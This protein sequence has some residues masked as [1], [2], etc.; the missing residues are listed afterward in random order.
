MALFKSEKLESLEDLLLDQLRDIYDAEHRIVKSL[1]NMIEKA[2]SD[3]LR[4]AFEH[5]L[6][7]TKQQVTRLEK[8]FELLGEEAK[9]EVCQA[10][11]GLLEE[12]EEMLN[13]EGKPEVRDAGMIASAQRVEHYE[14]AAYGNARNLARRLGKNEVADLL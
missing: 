2:D 5:H 6:D 3:S 10:S 8:C 7:E 9:R 11:K 12:S 1:P 4:K 14:M 13:K